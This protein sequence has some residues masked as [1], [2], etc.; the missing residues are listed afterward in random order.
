[1]QKFKIIGKPL[2]GEKYVE[3]RKERKKKEG[4]RIMPSLV[5]ITSASARTTFVRVHFA[6]TNNIVWDVCHKSHIYLPNSQ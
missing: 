6:R 4:R 2:L 1:M 3:G 5:A